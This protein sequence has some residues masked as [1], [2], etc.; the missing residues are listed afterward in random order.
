MGWLASSIHLHA[1]SCS[2]ACMEI[3]HAV[4]LSSCASATTTSTGHDCLSSLPIMVLCFVPGRCCV[5]WGPSRRTRNPGRRGILISAG[6]PT[7]GRR[8]GRSDCIEARSNR[9]Q[10]PRAAVAF[11]LRKNWKE[12]NHGQNRQSGWPGC[13]RRPFSGLAH[14]GKKT[15]GCFGRLIQFGCGQRVPR[16][17]PAGWGAWKPLKRL[18]F[19]LFCLISAR[20]GGRDVGLRCYWIEACPRGHNPDNNGSRPAKE[21]FQNITAPVYGTRT[22]V[23][24]VRPFVM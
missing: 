5:V 7:E 4:C 2:S 3:L 24:C 9:S 13:W 22:R 1:H 16:N 6:S 23:L 15:L 20:V 21:A 11:A 17:I 18:Y 14:A 19:L 10:D 8:S 12:W